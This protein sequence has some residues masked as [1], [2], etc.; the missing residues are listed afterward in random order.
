VPGDVERERTLAGGDDEG[1]KAGGGRTSVALM[2]CTGSNLSILNK[3]S[4]ASSPAA[5]NN[6]LMAR[7][8]SGGEEWKKNKE[9]CAIP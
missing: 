1:L 2:R 4:I 9:G 3:R 7:R 5:L 8:M 6:D